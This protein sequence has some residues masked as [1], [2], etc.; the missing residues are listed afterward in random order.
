MV[1]QFGMSERDRPAGG[2]RQ[3]AG[4]LPRPRVRPA[5]GDLRA[6][7]RDGGRRGQAAAGRGAMRAP[8]AILTDNRELLDRIAQALLERETIDREDLER[9]VRGEP[10]PPRTLPPSRTERAR[11]QRAGEPGAAAGPRAVSSAA[12]RPNPA[13]RECHAAGASFAAGDARMRSAPAAGTRGGRRTRPGAFTPP[14]FMLTGAGPGALEALARFGGRL[15]LERDHR[16]RMGSARRQRVAVERAGPAM[17]RAGTP[18]GCCRSA[19][20]SPCRPSRPP[21]GRRLE[22]T[23]RSNGRS[24]S[25]SST[26][27]PT[28]SATAAATPGCDA[29]VAHAEDAARATVPRSSTSAASPPGP[30]ATAECRW[31]RSCAGRSRSIEALVRELSHAA[32]LDRHREGERG[33]RRARCRRRRR[34]RR[35]RRCGS[36][37]RWRPSWPRRGP[38]W[39]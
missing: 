26:S 37:R 27:R 33:S 20:V 7:R 32:P 8:R 13:A 21:S 10:L 1:T 2:R 5:S 25:A 18:R 22:A 17:G 3:G 4:D 16:R 31:T 34:E 35:L 30:A 39:C 19:S 24:S 15:G 38:A 29:A 23:S 6:H 14:R 11:G 12:R 9:L 28:A 36:T